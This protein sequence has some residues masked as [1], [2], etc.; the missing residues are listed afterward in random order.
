MSAPGWSPPT[1]LDMSLPVLAVIGARA[2]AESRIAPFGI[3]AVVW[4]NGTI[5]SADLGAVSRAERVTPTGVVTWEALPLVPR[6]R[7]VPIRH[8]RNHE[9]AEET[10]RGVSDLSEAPWLPVWALATGCMS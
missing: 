8:S 7:P 5:I 6:C 4:R 2:F 3:H 1:M 9:R 10:D